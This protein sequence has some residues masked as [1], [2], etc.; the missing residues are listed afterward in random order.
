MASGIGTGYGTR[1]F[2]TERVKGKLRPV[3]FHQVPQ[4]P[5]PPPGPLQGV[6]DLTVPERIMGLRSLSSVECG[7]SRHCAQ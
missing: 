6:C 1:R 5:Y 7:R 3:V 2:Q 4:K